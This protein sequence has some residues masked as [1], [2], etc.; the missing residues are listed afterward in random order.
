[1]RIAAALTLVLSLLFPARASATPAHYYL[2]LGDSLAAGFLA[3]R[4]DT[5]RGYADLLYAR[6]RGTDP[7]LRLVKLGCSG[8]TTRSMSEGG[9]CDYPAGS[10]LRQAVRFLREHR[11]Q[12]RYLTVDIGA[13]DLSRCYSRPGADA[14]CVARGLRSG[15]GNLPRI[16]GP[17]Y[18]A[19][20]PGVRAAGMTYYDPFLA[21]WRDGAFGR[22][23]ADASVDVQQ[24]LAGMQA[25][26][27]L[28][29]GYGIANAFA[30]FHT[31][32]LTG[33][34]AT[35]YGNL[36]V[37]VATVCRLTTMCSNGDVHATVAGYGMIARAFARALTG[38]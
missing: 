33:Q 14:A 23:A 26:V 12:V 19:A 16:L 10:Q 9:V 37:A 3:G 32:Q 17:L 31:T 18:A 36:P 20:G 8:E 7:A 35:P 38:S 28:A 22:L 34:V 4:G 15:V 13:N 30:A 6:L 11:G 24:L 21:L 25:A 2:A 27:Y 5:D 29:F 1:V